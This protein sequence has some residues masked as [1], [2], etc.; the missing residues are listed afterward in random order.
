MIA[1]PFLT[2]T[3]IYDAGR[4]G[5]LQVLWILDVSGP[6]LYKRDA[7]AEAKGPNFLLPK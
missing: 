7:I 5:V 6:G 4:I 2:K 1:P 3:Q